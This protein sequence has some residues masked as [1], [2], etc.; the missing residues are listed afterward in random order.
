MT[1]PPLTLANP[2]IKTQSLSFV[3]VG[4]CRLLK[5]WMAAEKGP[6]SWSCLLNTFT[7]TLR[8]I[9]GDFECQ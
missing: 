9:Y 2:M 4:T 6:G 7:T 1:S 8:S 5:L 3:T